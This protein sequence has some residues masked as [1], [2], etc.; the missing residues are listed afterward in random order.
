MWAPRLLSRSAKSSYSLHF[1]KCLVWFT[2]SRM[3][4]DASKTLFSVREA[5]LLILLVTVILPVAVFVP[6]IVMRMMGFD[7]SNLGLT[8][9]NFFFFVLVSQCLGLI[10]ALLAIWRRIKRRKLSWTEV[11]LRKVSIGRSLKY[12]AGY[13]GIA[14]LGIIGL[15]IILVAV[16]VEPSNE[17]S[18]VGGSLF[19]SLW[20]NIL[21][22]VGI[23]PVIEEILF[24]GV[25]LERL[26]HIMK[27][28]YAISLGALIF[29]FAH[30]DPVKII[31]LLPLAFYISY[32]YYRLRS[33]YPS[34]VLHASWNLI[35]LLLQR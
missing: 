26:L 11:G 1:V 32:M 3:K 5:L 34:I 25:L 33:I 2:I 20:S 31:M 12:I 19:G 17:P 18:S 8:G 29:A 27:P 14:L 35:V 30:L 22:T 7:I 4:S 16:G 24:R 6:F 23:V 13:Y 9:K 15:L 21:I 28:F 10:I